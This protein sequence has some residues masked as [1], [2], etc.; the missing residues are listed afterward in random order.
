LCDENGAAIVLGEPITA[1]Q[2]GKLRPVITQTAW[3]QSDFSG[4]LGA[5]WQAGKKRS[6]DEGGTVLASVYFKLA[7][8]RTA[9]EF[10]LSSLTVSQ[11]G[12][13]ISSCS[14]V[15][16]YP[17][18]AWLIDNNGVQR[19]FYSGGLLVLLDYEKISGAV[20]M[21]FEPPPEEEPVSSVS[22]AAIDSGKENTADIM[23]ADSEAAAGI[24][25][26]AKG[27]VKG[28]LLLAVVMI[29]VIVLMLCSRACYKTYQN[30]YASKRKKKEGGA[31]NRM[32]GFLANIV[33]F[34]SGASPITEPPVPKTKAAEE[35]RKFVKGTEF[36]AEPEGVLDPLWGKRIGHK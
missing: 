23:P 19:G 36:T 10:G 25:N 3:R 31:L 26:S 22:A 35:K 32:G 6:I 17:D 27:G 30:F 16:V 33:D 11:S 24:S 2:S 34:L 13:L 5:I 12:E 15:G 29:L 8:G 9:L 21:A 28:Q 20:G 7:E 1:N 18:G 14:P 4:S